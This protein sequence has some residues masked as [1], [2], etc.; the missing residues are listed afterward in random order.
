MNTEQIKQIEA[1]IQLLKNRP[2][3]EKFRFSSSV[4]TKEIS[5][6]YGMDSATNQKIDAFISANRGNAQTATLYEE[7]MLYL[8]R[9]N[10]ETDGAFSRKNGAINEAKFYEYAYIDK[11]TWS[12][13]KNNLIVPKK[14]TVLKLAIALRLSEDEAMRLMQK[15]N[16][17]FDYDDK[18]DLIVL[19]LLNLKIYDITTVIDTLEFYQMQGQ[20]YFDS[21]YDSPE[22]QARKRKEFKAQRK[23]ERQQKLSDL[24]DS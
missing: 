9:L 17:C 24:S 16:D 10:R 5:P 14:K 21:I 23:R 6:I 4:M 8:E 22:E 7:V 13:M 2:L 19:A 15:I 12:S 20:P 11:S 18:Q 3:K 1:Q